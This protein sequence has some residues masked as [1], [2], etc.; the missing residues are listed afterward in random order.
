MRVL[1]T[2]A[3]GFLG[4]EVLARLL[5]RGDEVVAVVR[6]SASR[7]HDTLD[8]VGASGDVEVLTGDLAAGD[9][10][11]PEGR[12]DTIIH[13]AASISFTLP[14]EEARA[15][16]VEGTRRVLEIARA[17]GARLVH[18]ST[19]YVAGAHRNTYEQT[20]AEAE[21]LVEASGVP[22]VIG[23]PSIVVG[24]AETGWT[25]AFNVLY[26]PLRAFARGL[27]DPVPAAPGGRVDVVPVDWVADCLV[28]LADTPDATGV[29]E[30]VAGEAA[31]TIADL[32]E[33]TCAHID[34]PR[35]R[36]VAPGGEAGGDHADV[37]V[38]YF[39]VDTVFD[40]S[41]VAALAGP[42]PALE[43]YFGRLMEFAEAAKWGKKRLTRPVAQ[44]PR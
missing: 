23:R 11:V 31:P 32:I 15:I 21:A 28:T 29:V 9:V 7:I 34:R 44:A 42:P 27:L 30:L 38:P 41:R 43:S 10:P 18:V 1:L 40:G 2:G 8:L 26:W 24:E 22:Y 5:D 3:T 19:A 16:N 6:G 35:P 17:T 4:M 13:C 20:K 37:Y 39:D 14:L 12:I 25:P 36:L 33:L